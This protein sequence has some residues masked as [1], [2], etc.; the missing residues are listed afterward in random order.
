MANILINR[1]DLPILI[2]NFSKENNTFKI[3]NFYPK[4]GNSNGF[5]C[6]FILDGKKCLLDIFYKQK[7]TTIVPVGKNIETTNLLIEYIKNHSLNPDIEGKQLTFETSQNFC[8]KMKDY[9]ITAYPDLVSINQ[10]ENLFIFIGY[11]QDQVNIHQYKNKILIQGKPLSVYSLIMNYI[12]ENTSINLKDFSNDLCNNMSV[13]TPFSMVRKNMENMLGLAYDYIDEP[14]KK[15]LSSSIIMLKKYKYDFIEDYS[16]CVTGAFKTLEGYLKKILKYKFDYQF[17][18]NSFELFDS[19]TW[20]I[21]PKYIN[22]S[23]KEEKLL[24]SLYKIY[25][26]KRNIYLHS[27]INPSTTPIIA[28]YYDAESIF[29]EIVNIIK[30][31]YNV[32]MGV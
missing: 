18:H 32:F 28:S 5:T 16:G 3:I 14:L 24:C 10:K 2:E 12:A 23:A 30:N 1:N 19:S 29:N 9:F 22:C 27:K 15:T 21:K 4:K 26:N 20:T 13:N 25:K 7:K 11:N 17:P 31:S 6:N 8:E